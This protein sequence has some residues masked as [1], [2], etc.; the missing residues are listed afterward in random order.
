M[1]LGLLHRFD[2]GEVRRDASSASSY[3]TDGRLLYRVV[4]WWSAGRWDLLVALENCL[5]LEVNA[6]TYGELDLMGLRP[7]RSPQPPDAA[8][9]EQASPSHRRGDHVVH[10]AGVWDR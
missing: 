2:H 10:R 5:T 7:V 6:Y 3:L 1:S 9:C 8:S 4:G